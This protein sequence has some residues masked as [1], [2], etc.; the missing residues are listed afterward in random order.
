MSQ[1]IQVRTLWPR[2]G[3]LNKK[4][5]AEDLADVLWSHGFTH[6][7]CIA[8]LEKWLF[9]RDAMLAFAVD[10]LEVLPWDHHAHLQ[11]AG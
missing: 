7:Q 9:R 11:D 2:P 8:I 10:H 5:F 3:D 6:S 1:G 4:E